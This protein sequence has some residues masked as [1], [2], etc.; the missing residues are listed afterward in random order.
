MPTM[1]KRPDI[2]FLAFACWSLLVLLAYVNGHELNLALALDA[3]RSWSGERLSWHGVTGALPGHLKAC[4]AAL[5]CAALCL[6]AGRPA[7]RWLGARGGPLSLAL[8]TGT[9]F[10]L[11]LAAGLTGL[12]YSSLFWTAGVALGAAGLACGPGPSPKRAPAGK[13]L[14]PRWAAWGALWL[15][16]G[17]AAVN[18]LGALAPEIGYDSLIQHLADPAQY[19]AAH[20][21][22]FNDL[23]FLAQH[24]AAFQMIYGWLMPAGGDAGAK[25]VHWLF[26]ISAAW[27]LRDWLAGRWPKRDAAVFAAAF[28]LT[29]FFGVLSS[30]AYVD[31]GLVFYSAC[32]LLA[33]WGSWLQGVL[34]GFGMGVKFSGGILLAG[35]LAALLLGRDGW[36]A[37]ARVLAGAAFVS[38][39]WGARN[40]LNAGNPVYPFLYSV[41]GGLGWDSISAAEYLAE[42]KSYGAVSGL[43]GHIAIP[44]L[45]FVRDR[46]ALDDGSLGPL[47]LILAPLA[48]LIR[49]AGNSRRLA[50]LAAALWALY[51]VSPRQ[52]RYALPFLP[53]TFALLL[54]AVRRAWLD[55]PWTVRPGIALLGSLL[56]VQAG[57][58]LSAV[59]LWSNPYPS[60][61]GCLDRHAFLSRI[62]SPRD[63]DTGKSLYMAA[64]AKLAG[65]MPPGASGLMLGDGKVYYLPGRWR[66][67]ALF[68]PRIMKRL[69]SA[70][71]SG[72]E[73]AKRLKQRGITN[74]LYNVGGSIHIEFT[75]RLYDWSD[76][77]EALMESFAAEWLKP[78]WI[79]ESAKREPMYMFFRLEKGRHG[80][81]RYLPGIDTA[82]AGI[83]ERTA[84]GETAEARRKARDLLR[85]YPSSSYL[86]ARVAD[87]LAERRK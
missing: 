1:R 68:N 58:S 27:A 23:S 60:V 59:Y 50:A 16:A 84:R 55:R 79:V 54:P 81:P 43:D 80:F 34:L 44:W 7:A 18:F 30:R 57:I 29:P 19:I 56:I 69:I 51:I 6:S 53:P 61:T 52:V 37:A 75:H 71:A 77:E 8:G 15:A 87:I 20:R 10:L 24:P 85:R 76:R 4:V 9:A 40:W 82:L 36:R 25:V 49:P 26:G 47:A 78:L 67:N 83:E 74:V 64:A 38:A 14:I 21:V 13:P 5:I 32:A 31:L 70:S 72:D 73:V 48:L 17:S 12:Y 2:A 28:Y 33:P 22:Y 35:W 45:T 65:T 41:F 66:V 86:P 11:L 62:I 39:C 3:L 42:V 46:G 63:P